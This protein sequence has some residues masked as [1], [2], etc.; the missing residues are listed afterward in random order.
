MSKDLWQL[1]DEGGV[2]VRCSVHDA[3]HAKWLVEQ[4]REGKMEK[5]KVRALLC[6][7]DKEG[8]CLLSISDTFDQI[9]AAVWREGQMEKENGAPAPEID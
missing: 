7:E 5:E 8:S 1:F 4:V 3:D 2:V 6:E 9:E